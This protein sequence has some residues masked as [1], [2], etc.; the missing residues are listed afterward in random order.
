M[1]GCK[2][3]SVLCFLLV[4][5]SP[6]S[7]GAEPSGVSQAG[8]IT[9]NGIDVPVSP[10]LSPQ[11]HEFMRQVLAENRFGVPEADIHAERK[12]Q[13]SIMQGFLAPMLQRYDVTIREQTIGGVFTQ[14]VTPR[15]GVLPENQ[16]RILLNLHGG[17]FTTGARTASLVESVPLSASMGIKII[18]IDY[19]MGPE[20]TF[21]AG[22]EDV[23]AVYREVLKVYKPEN[24][25]I[26]GCSAGGLLTAQALAWFDHQNLPQPGAAGI[27][28]AS[29]GR[30]LAGDA[31][32]LA[33][34]LNGMF[35]LP[36]PPQGDEYVAAIGSTYFSGVDPLDPLVY[37]I[38]SEALLAKFP[39]VLFIT[40]SR[41][42]EFSAAL[43]S[44]NVLG[45][46]GKKSQF[47]GWDGLNHAFFYNSELPESRE[48]YSVMVDFFD[49]Y[50]KR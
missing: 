4:L 18:S 17:G 27:F 2:G 35:A 36:P 40:A 45:S 38:V 50:L 5:A 41:G 3:W 48:A 46:L 43:N 33:G 47:Y 30:F 20:F 32:A 14:I 24:I 34:P 39:P 42:F 1:M 6:A 37:P 31:L 13:D 12:R 29:L 7:L 22:S 9:L 49:E 21:P 26:Y 8:V 28:C 15:D 10:S 44:H 11:A 19:R 16:Q 23:A 25:G